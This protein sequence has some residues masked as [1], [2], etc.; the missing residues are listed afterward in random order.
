VLEDVRAEEVVE[1]LLAMVRAESVNPP[2]DTR[3][4]GSL[5][6][7]I[8]ETEGID[9]ERVEGRPGAVNVVARLSGGRADG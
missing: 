3:A 8:C 6:V 4:C 7:D 5:L 9:V 2:A 1:L